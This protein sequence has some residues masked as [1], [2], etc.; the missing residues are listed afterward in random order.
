MEQK[1]A[2]CNGR[3]VLEKLIG[4]G[5]FGKIYSGKAPSNIW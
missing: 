1:P 3:Y 4:E 5:G 2:V